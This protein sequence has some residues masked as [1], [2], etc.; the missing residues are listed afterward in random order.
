VASRAQIANLARRIE[1]LKPSGPM[2]L[3]VMDPGERRNELWHAM[4]RRVAAWVALSSTSLRGC[5]EEHWMTTRA[6]IARL[7][8][9]IEELAR[10]SDTRPDVA[11]VWQDKDETEEHALARHPAASAARHVYIVT[12]AGRR[13]EA[14]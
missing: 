7:T 2:T 1:A 9:R 11:Y 4:R 6:Q 3:I 14:A 12:W 10:R 5:Q 13:P 8:A